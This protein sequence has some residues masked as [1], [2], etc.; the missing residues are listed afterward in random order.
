MGQRETRDGFDTS[1]TAH[2][3]RI[4]TR[5][6]QRTVKR[7]QKCAP[8]TATVGLAQLCTKHASESKH[9]YTDV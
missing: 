1:P 8:F 7:A 6:R 4:N 5:T 9:T 3:W 2:V